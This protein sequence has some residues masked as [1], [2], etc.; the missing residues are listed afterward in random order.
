MERFAKRLKE[1]REFKKS[2]NPMWTQKYV[3]DKIGMA[4]T[5]YTAYENGTKLPPIDIVDNL[6]TL[7]GVSTDYL[8]GRIEK[9]TNPQTVSVAGKEINL[10]PDEMN[11]FEELKKHPVLFHK[12][13][14]DPEKMIKQMIQLQKMEKLLLDDDEDPGDGFGSLKD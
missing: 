5:T 1:C 12:L 11:I 2:N 4:R 3:A 13:A 8:L 9:P 6:A 14:A 7:L 10:S